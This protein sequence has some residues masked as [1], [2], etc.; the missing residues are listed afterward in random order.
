MRL[1][2]LLITTFSITSN[3]LAQLPSRN[4]RADLANL[5]IRHRT[6]HYAMAGNCEASR[7]EEYGRALEYVYHE[8]AKGFGQLIQKDKPIGNK[9][10]SQT[11]DASLDGDQGSRFKVVILANKNDYDAFTAAYFGGRAEHTR[12]LFVKAFELLII[13]DD[14]DTSE[15]YEVLFH[16]AF[17][18][19]V[20]RY[21]P[22]APVWINEGLATYY[23]TARATPNG[24]VFDR[25]I[26]WYFGAVAQARDIRQLVPLDKLMAANRVE[27]YDTTPIKGVRFDRRLLHYG[28][29][30][31]LV[32]FMLQDK[33]GQTILQQYLIDLSKA[34]NRR[35]V[36]RI[37]K[38]HYPEKLLKRITVPW[39]DFV[40]RATY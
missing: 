7:F 28:Q 12:G 21:V 10:P 38:K 5:E 29:A 4:L 34:K 15:T 40:N 27:F 2:L 8:Y 3:T 11:N 18:Q 1:L 25:P 33:Q 39:L 37:A 20:H 6:D 19:F 9:A 31:T 35:E 36:R 16:E 24:L 14:A 32:A 30:Y 13:R 26:S 23:G 17:H 22:M